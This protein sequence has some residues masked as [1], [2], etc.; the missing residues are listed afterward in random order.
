MFSQAPVCSQGGTLDIR[1]GDLPLLLVTYGVTLKTCSNLTIWRPTPLSDIWWWQLKLKRA[2]CILLEC[3]L[4]TACKRSLWRL[5][6]YACLSV[7]LFTGGCLPQCMLGYTPPSSPEQTRRQDRNRHAPCTVHAGRYGQ[8]AGDASCWNAYLVHL[9]S[10]CY[11][12]M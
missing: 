10:E 9:I 8:Q 7:I 4:V 3:Y 5:R 2:V 11:H 12:I 6:F 1:P